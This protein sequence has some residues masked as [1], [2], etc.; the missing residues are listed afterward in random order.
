[1]CEKSSSLSQVPPETQ[2]GKEFGQLSM[3]WV[4]W[5]VAGR[6]CLGFGD[7]Q[8]GLQ[9]QPWLFAV[10]WSWASRVPLQGED[11]EPLLVGLLC[12]SSLQARFHVPAMPSPGRGST[13]VSVGVILFL[14]LHIMVLT[15]LTR[16]VSWTGSAH[17]RPWSKSQEA[18][19]GREQPS[20][21]GR[22]PIFFS[23]SRSQG[24]SLILCESP[25]D[26]RIT[27]WGKKCIFHLGN[28]KT[29]S[30]SSGPSTVQKA[31]ELFSLF[32]ALHGELCRE[33]HS[34]WG[35]WVTL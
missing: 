26:P 12:R 2:S 30:E 20:F 25:V 3:L 15:P 9:I 34:L 16:C 22:K 33:A 5:C 27:P 4:P 17:H 1:M 13:E 31:A 8:K 32:P 35:A 18:H 24:L 28:K 10:L 7:R 29:V 6:A 23:P 14:S 19:S 21:G 11:K